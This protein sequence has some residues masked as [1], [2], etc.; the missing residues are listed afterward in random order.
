MTGWRVFHTESKGQ[1]AHTKAAAKGGQQFDE[2]MSKADRKDSSNTVYLAVLGYHC[3]VN[4][5]PE[6]NPAK[7]LQKM[8]N[9]ILRKLWTYLA[10]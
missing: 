4:T 3:E 6:R 2:G 10:K 1:V 5:N 7:K 9:Y 8:R